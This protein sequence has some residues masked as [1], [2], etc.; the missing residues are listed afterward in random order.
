[1]STHQL[2]DTLQSASKHKTASLIQIL[3]PPQHEHHYSPRDR[4]HNLQL[5]TRTSS[6]KDMNCLIR[7]LFKDITFTCA[8]SQ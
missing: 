6:L 4:S 5:P 8:F 2:M 3:L 7:K 1:M